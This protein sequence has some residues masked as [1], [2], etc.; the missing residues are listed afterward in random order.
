MS[1]IEV[2]QQRVAAHHAQSQ[3]VRTAQGIADADRWEAVS[4]LFKANPRR[5]D[6]VEVNRLVR[7][8]TPTTTLLDVGGGAGRFA[9]PLALYCQHVT[10][11]EP[12]PSMREGLRQLA[13]EAQIENV[14]LVAKRWE[15]AEVQAADVVL[16]AHVLYLIGDVRAFVA[17]LVA[18]ARRKILV[19]LFMRPLSARYAPFWRCVHGEERHQLPGAGELVQV[20]WEMDIYPDL[21]MFEPRPPRAFKDWQA[22][23]ETLRRRTHAIPGTAEDIRLQQAMR[24]LLSERRDGYVVKGAVP[25]RLALLSWERAQGSRAPGPGGGRVSL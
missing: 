4:P 15:E 14:S 9:L 12:S 22:A 23:L 6:D 17:K 25:D 21:E 18:H 7:E 1:A 3:R 24:E 20:L 19:L 8:V 16:S 11:V 10:V 2:W 13:G 5:T